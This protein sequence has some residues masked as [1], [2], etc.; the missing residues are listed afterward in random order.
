MSGGNERSA[1]AM[2]DAAERGRRSNAAI[3]LSHP[4]VEWESPGTRIEG[5][6]PYRGHDGIRRYFADLED[7]WGARHVTVDDY[8]VVGGHIVALGRARVEGRAG[9]VEFDYPFGTVLEIRDG[10]LARGR[11]Y[12]DH[13]EALAAAS[14]ITG[15]KA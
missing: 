2:I 11:V 13:H 4:D 6:E 9:G 12:L 15:A 8:R 7:A 3:A 14:A 5:G 10:K 1:A